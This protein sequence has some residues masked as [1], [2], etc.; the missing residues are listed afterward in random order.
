MNTQVI[1]APTMAQRSAAPRSDW[2]S[3]TSEQT[4]QPTIA[5]R[6]APPSNRVITYHA[7]SPRLDNGGSF[8]PMCDPGG[9]GFDLPLIE[10]MVTPE[11]PKAGEL[12]LIGPTGDGLVMHAEDHCDR[13]RGEPLFNLSRHGPDL[14][15]ASS[16]SRIATA[17]ASVNVKRST[18][19]TKIWPLFNPGGASSHSTFCTGNRCTLTSN[20]SSFGTR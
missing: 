8:R 10:T 20:G 1:D 3:P 2:G 18:V 15:S 11:G 14:P 6:I 19:K 5:P 17:R 4:A 12:P 7:R 13:A 9:E 16:P